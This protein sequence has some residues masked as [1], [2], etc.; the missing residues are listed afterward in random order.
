LIPS[1]I[2]PSLA[3]LPT[4]TGATPPTDSE[5]AAQEA[6]ELARDL[7]SV[8]NELHRYKEDALI[9]DSNVPFAPLDL[10]RYWDVSLL[11]YI[12]I[13]VLM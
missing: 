6:E 3:A 7:R 4:A 2:L 11:C 1:P 13:L 12:V 10:V 9:G 5:K 8:R